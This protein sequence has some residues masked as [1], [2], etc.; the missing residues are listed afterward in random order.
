MKK[1][2]SPIRAK[3]KYCLACEKRYHPDIGWYRTFGVQCRCGTQKGI[4]FSDVSADRKL[5]SE[6]IK[7]AN[8]SRLSPSELEFTIL[9]WI[10][11]D[12]AISI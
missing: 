1:K 4:F 12:A 9:K 7:K 2:S 10:E 6:I 3:V 8:V 5:L 11:Q